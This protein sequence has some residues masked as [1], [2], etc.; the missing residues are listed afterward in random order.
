MV[1]PSAVVTWFVSIFRIAGWSANV[2][3]RRSGSCM[4]SAMNRARLFGEQTPVSGPWPADSSV[5]CAR[6]QSRG[7]A[8]GRALRTI[9]LVRD[10]PTI[11]QWVYEIIA[12][13][14]RNRGREFM[15]ITTEC[16]NV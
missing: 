11:Q 9:R 5:G 8:M 12:G 2:P 16:V 14:E 3:A 7:H 13:P 4:I 6:M 1:L 10:Y 15:K